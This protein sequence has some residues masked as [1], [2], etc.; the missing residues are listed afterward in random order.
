MNTEGKKKRGRQT[1]RDLIIENELN[2]A[3]GEVAGGGELNR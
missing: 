3:G 2:F 1:I